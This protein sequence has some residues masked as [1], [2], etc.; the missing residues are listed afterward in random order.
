[1]SL[2][3]EDSVST[4][5]SPQVTGVVS[6]ECACNPRPQLRAQLIR[7][8]SRSGRLSSVIG[9]SGHLSV[10]SCKLQAVV[11]GAAIRNALCV[12][13]LVLEPSTSTGTGTGSWE[14]VRGGCVCCATVLLL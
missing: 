11:V 14:T 3:I 1:V 5:H 13:V 6:G 7:A 4:V 8:N 12:L 10:A 9:R 2:P